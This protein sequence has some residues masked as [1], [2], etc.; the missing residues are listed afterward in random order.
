MSDVTAPTGRSTRAMRFLRL[1]EQRLSIVFLIALFGILMLQIVGRFV[2][3]APVVWSE[4]IA[5]YLF[6]WVVFVGASD[7]IRSRT[8]IGVDLVPTL[9]PLRGR[10]ALGLVMD[11]V[12]IIVLVVLIRLGVD[13]TLRAHR[14]P[15]VTTDLPQSF[16]Y[17]V[18][19][20]GALL[21]TLR[22]GLRMAD[23][24]R[25]FVLGRDIRGEKLAAEASERLQ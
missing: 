10:L 6:A 2:L 14:L 11:T 17:G 12:L 16:L 1:F 23:D 18:V 5:R 13:G 21:M 7:A 4:E 19:P 8:H 3:D 15:S 25:G 24:A 22:L 20:V 9:L